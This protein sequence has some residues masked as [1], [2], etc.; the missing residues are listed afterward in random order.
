MSRSHSALDRTITTKSSKWTKLV[1]QNPI[2]TVAALYIGPTGATN[3]HGDN[4]QDFIFAMDAVRRVAEE[5]SRVTVQPSSSGEGSRGSLGEGKDLR[6]D[7]EGLVNAGVVEALCRNVIELKGDT[8]ADDAM[9]S[10]YPPF[11]IL[12]FVVIGMNNGDR[13][14]HSGNQRSTVD[15]RAMSA[16]MDNWEEMVDRWWKEPQNTLKQDATH[17]PERLLV[18][19]LMGYLL[20]EDSSMYLKIFH[21][22]SHTLSL[23]SRHWVHC[24]SANIAR[25]NLSILRSI[26][27]FKFSQNV[28]EYLKEH[29]K[30]PLDS[31]L[32]KIYT[33]IRAPSISSQSGE[34]QTSA[35]YLLQTMSNRLA[36]GDP[37]YAVEDLGF[38]HD[39]YVGLREFAASS[40]NTSELDDFADALRNSEAYWRNAFTLMHIKNSDKSTHTEKEVSVAVLNLAL[41]LILQRPVPEVAQLMRTW[42]QTGL[43]GVL[44]E[45][46]EE[47]IRVPGATR[48]LTFF[49]TTIK[50]S[51]LSP[52]FPVDVLEA[53]KDEFPRQRAVAAVMRYETEQKGNQQNNTTE[54]NANEDDIPDAEDPIWINGLWQAMGWL[55]GVCHRDHAEHEGAQGIENRLV[56]TTGSTL[57][58]RR[59]C[60]KKAVSKCSSCKEFWYC[61]V[62][63]QRLD[64]KEHKSICKNNF[65][66]PYMQTVRAGTKRLTG[67]NAAK[68]GLMGLGPNDSEFDSDTSNAKTVTVVDRLKG[69]TLQTGRII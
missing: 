64:W 43:F 33:G 60:G 31:L 21:P 38:C 44:D 35:Q 24:T 63:C 61:G 40:S 18:S 46:M 52:S 51:C 62:E 65:A 32:D 59:S 57:C 10:F 11:V 6:K 8:M 13:D 47:L 30:P 68:L 69:L 14:E 4:G 50:E 55:E 25:L 56:V 27:F 49:Y 45:T 66:A 16:I 1:S 54:K 5:L 9:S 48:L 19:R 2:R 28:E 15:K 23:I 17:E 34:L 58:A 37:S 12:Y 7:L 26:I 3:S 29:E 22:S 36:L 20:L 67:G 53:L 42:I 39:V 41:K